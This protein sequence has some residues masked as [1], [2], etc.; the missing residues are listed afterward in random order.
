MPGMGPMP[1]DNDARV[2]YGLRW[3][4]FGL[5]GELPFCRDHC[6]A[7]VQRV[8]LTRRASGTSMR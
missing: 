7:V 2:R 3:P 1:G 6:Q 4:I 5:R 8:S